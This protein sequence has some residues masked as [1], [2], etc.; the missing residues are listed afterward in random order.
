[1]THIYF[2]C[3]NSERVVVDPCGIE[4]EDLIEAHQRAAGVIQQFVNSAGPVDWRAWTLHVSD[5]E[6]D[7]IFVMP[8]SYVLGRPH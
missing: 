7:E 3:A 8:F 5:E 4:V 1:M 2:H 6:G